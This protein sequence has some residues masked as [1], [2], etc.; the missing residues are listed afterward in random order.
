MHLKYVF[1]ILL[2][3]IL[4]VSFT[5][6]TKTFFFVCILYNK[7]KYDLCS[8]YNQSFCNIIININIFV[9]YIH[10]AIYTMQLQAICCAFC[11]YN[12]I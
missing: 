9:Y 5:K 10:G 3:Y 7:V 1:L 4:K 11:I 12:F 6:S 8:N 2:Y